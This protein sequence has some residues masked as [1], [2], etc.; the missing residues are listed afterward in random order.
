[1]KKYQ[2]S[3]WIGKDILIYRSIRSFTKEQYSAYLEKILSGGKEKIEDELELA[4]PRMI[5]TKK[6][7]KE[8]ET[9]DNMSLDKLI[10][11]RPDIVI[12]AA[13]QTYVSDTLFRGFY[14]FHDKESETDDS[15]TKETI[16]SKIENYNWECVPI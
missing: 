1:M 13:I 4:L 15:C 16:I 12:C 8:F 2:L 5:G 9:W 6:Y 7:E 10:K 14:V 11:R 3:I